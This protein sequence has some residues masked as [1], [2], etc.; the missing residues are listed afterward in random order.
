MVYISLRK[1]G[2][3][4]R[5]ALNF[6]LAQHCKIDSTQDIHGPPGFKIF[7]TKMDKYKMLQG[8]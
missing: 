3:S 4:K 8:Y 6:C 7:K 1:G 2:Q 5:G